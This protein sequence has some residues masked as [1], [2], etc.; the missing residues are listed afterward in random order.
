MRINKAFFSITF[1]L[2]LISNY[3]SGQ[4]IEKIEVDKFTNEKKI[5][6][7]NVTIYGSAMA[8]Y[9]NVIKCYYRSVDTSAFIIFDGLNT[10]AGVIGEHDQVIFLLADKS[11]VY[12]TST[13]L[14]SYEIVG[15]SSVYRYHH[16]YSISQNSLQKLSSQPITS[17]RFYYDSKYHD[18]DIKEKRSKEFQKLSQ[19]FY[20]ELKK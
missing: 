4:K 18:V 1:F 9:P 11:T 17:I 7:D 6:T 5:L 12:I 13:G 20:N 14:Q 19:L 16:Q 8:L 15:S 10:A 2:I 3:S